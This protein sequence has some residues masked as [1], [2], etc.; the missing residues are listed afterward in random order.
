MDRLTIKYNE[1]NAE[2]Y[3]I[4]KESVGKYAPPI[5][6]IELAMKNTLFRVSVYDGTEIVA[7]ARMLG[8]MGLSYYVKDVVVRPEYQGKGI[9]KM[10]M[11]ELLTFINTNGLPG[12]EIYVEL[13]AL[14]D[15]AAFYEKLGF[16]SNDGIRLKM[17]YTIK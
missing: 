9:G 1:L 17:M 15:K 6:Q 12:T 10:L 16:S 11:N 8:D 3:F 5:K 14:P 13:C 7:M 2:E 4:L